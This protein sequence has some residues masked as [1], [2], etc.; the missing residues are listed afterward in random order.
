MERDEIRFL[1]KCR[2]INKF[3]RP[4]LHGL[5]GNKGIENH[6]LHVESQRTF[7]NLPT[8]PA[9]T[10]DAEGL[11]IQF[12]SLEFIPLPF[13]FFDMR[14]SLRNI[15]RYSHKH[16]KTKFRSRDGITLRGIHNDNAALSCSRKINV[17]HTN[18]GTTNDAELFPRL[19]NFFRNFCRTADKDRI[20]LPNDLFELLRF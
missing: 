6:E 14:I 5:F 9:K 17:I 3:N 10:H 18:T 1:D 20:V 2:E 13:T 8:D 11:T 15:S 4:F 12:C 7:R 16:R 19:D